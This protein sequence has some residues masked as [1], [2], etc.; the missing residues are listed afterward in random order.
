MS[1][2]HSKDM[3]PEMIVRKLVHGMGYRYR[4]HQKDLPGKPDLVFSSRKKIIFVHGCFWHQHND[5]KCKFAHTPKSNTDYW[6]PKLKRNV[7]RD[8][9]HMKELEQLGWDVLVV[10]ECETKPER[11]K[12]LETKIK[13]FLE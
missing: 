13:K 3:V 4:L 6:F 7:E 1:H 9:E 5:P 8:R 11:T 12:Y 2:I 10:W